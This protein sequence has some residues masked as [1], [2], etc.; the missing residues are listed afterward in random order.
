[1]SGDRAVI[2]GAGK[3]GRGFAAD[4][5]N[6]SGY[7]ITFVDSS[8]ELV[9]QLRHSRS[10][11]LLKTGSGKPP[12]TVRIAGF[13]AI[14]TAETTQLSDAVTGADLIV[15]AV[16]PR[17]FPE[18][19]GQLSKMLVERLHQ[20]PDSTVDIILCT[21]LSHAGAAF[22]THL[23]QGLP[24]EWRSRFD[25]QV[26]V[27]ESLVMRI[28]APPDADSLRRDPLMVWTNDVAELPVD[29]QAFRGPLPEIAGLRPVPDLEAEETRKLFTYNTCHAALAYWGALYGHEL[30][31]DCMADERVML[32][33]R[34]V[35]DE[36]SRTLQSEYGFSGDEMDAWISRVLR[37]TDNPHLS[38]SVARYGGDPIRKLR[39]GDRLVGPL[40]LALKNG[41]TAHYLTR[42]IAAAFL[43]QNAGDTT[44]C[45]IGEQIQQNGLR[46]TIV[47]RCELGEEEDAL[48]DAVIEA[49]ERIPLDV[50]WSDLAAQAGSLAFS[51]EQRYHGCGQSVLAAVLETVGAFDSSA[52]EAATALAGGLGMVGDA[53]CGALLGASLAFGILYP[54]RRQYF[55]GDRDN[56]YRCYRMA[57]ALRQRFIDSYGS[58]TCRDIHRCLMGRSFD[59]LDK[60]QLEAFEAA[61]AHDDKCTGVVARAAQWAVEI[62]GDERIAEEIQARRALAE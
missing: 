9:G 52:F 59:L 55:D 2:W 35:L 18:V 7:A 49:Y 19:A 58:I 53:S 46:A 10:Y 6:S 33:V 51:Y 16:F 54:R 30:I 42:A 5:L 17:A 61:G 20:K 50:E 4:I 27:V 36:C 21:N 3:I 57:Q 44:A 12:S 23:L 37:D 48:V 60:K 45:Q 40:L 39:R 56:K 11:S 25:D 43:Y 34:H 22:R 28:V 29:Q 41:I 1:M 15:V 62:I 14:S 8:P 32:E 26:G 47:D 38:D 31:P 13:E 24:A